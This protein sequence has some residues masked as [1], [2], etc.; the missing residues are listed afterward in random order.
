VV[1]GVG[2]CLI[3]GVV[4]MRWRV[5]VLCCDVQELA[6]LEQSIVD[7]EGKRQRKDRE[8]ARLQKNL[9]ELLT[10]Q[11][12]E[13]DSLR[14]KGLQL[15]VATATSAGACGH[16]SCARVRGGGLRVLLLRRPPWLLW[17]VLL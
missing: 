11:K 6:R 16:A 17:C 12:A 5:L 13:L 4:R 2:A 7:M 9:L 14:E 3:T 15:E 1:G 8:F 10:E